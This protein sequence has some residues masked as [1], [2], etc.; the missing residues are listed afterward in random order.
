MLEE[1]LR[2]IDELASLCRNTKNTWNVDRP[3][4]KAVRRFLL[5]ESRKQSERSAKDIGAWLDPYMGTPQ[6]LQGD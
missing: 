3:L 4:T 1:L 2:F 6:Y 5:G